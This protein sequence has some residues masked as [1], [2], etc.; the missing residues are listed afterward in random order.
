MR[1]RKLSSIALAS[2]MAV[3]GMLS[4]NPQMVAATPAK[5]CLWSGGAGDDSFINPSNWSDCDGTYPSNGDNLVFGSI[6]TTQKT[7]DYNGGASPE[8]G[9]IVFTDSGF[10]IGGGM[11]SVTN[12]MVD[13]SSGGTNRIQTSNFGIY[14]TSVVDGGNSDLSIFQASVGSES[15]VQLRHVTVQ[16]LNGGSA[17]SELT[18]GPSVT[19]DTTT[20]AGINTLNINSDFSTNGDLEAGQINVANGVAFTINSG[21]NVTSSPVN[22]GNGAT[23]SV[24]GFIT[25][26]VDNHSTMIV[27]GAVNGTVTAETGS[28]IKGTGSVSTAVVKQGADIAPG[29]SPG[30]LSVAT[31]ALS[32]SYREEIGGATTPCTDYDQIQASG[33]VN[34]TNGFLGVYLVNGFAPAVG[35][36]FTI[37][38]NQGISPV[39]GTFKGLPQGA[40]FSNAGYNFKISY[41]GGDGNDVTLTA[42]GKTPAKSGTKGSTGKTPG[43]PD[44]GLASSVSHPAV[45][46]AISGAAALALLV[47]ARKLRPKEI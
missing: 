31:L 33:T 13:Q 46:L 47:I 1:L 23:L 26:N 11:L 44:T 21:D 40:T 27:D 30:C 24:T 37:I 36:T 18:I 3:T 17:N 2:F 38:D 7:I 12:G 19:L 15:S 32:G 5:T 35:Q 39:L 16:N 9:S 42:L 34:L 22:V 6:S 45:T 10:F 25:G 4:I 28:V 8:F 41:I 29:H 14:S 20:N 43:S